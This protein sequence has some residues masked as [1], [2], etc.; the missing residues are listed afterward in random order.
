MLEMSGIQ[1]ASLYLAI[2]MI[3]VIA[4]AYRVV[5][6][7]AKDSISLGDGEDLGMQRRIRIHANLIEYA[8]MFFLGLFA[9]AATS[10]PVVLIHGFGAVFTL[11]RC[12]HAFNFNNKAEK[13]GAP[14]GRFFG[15]LFTWLSTL[16]LALTL[17]FYVLMG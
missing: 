16:A 15:T 6:V 17:L 3:L 1:A 7:R 5:Q 11:A 12:G 13:S 2:Q 4:L 9:L 10:A 14:K 8:P